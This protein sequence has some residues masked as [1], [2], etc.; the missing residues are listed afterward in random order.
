MSP[1][2]ASEKNTPKDLP[3]IS[4][5]KKVVKNQGNLINPLTSLRNYFYPLKMKGLKATLSF[6]DGE[7][8]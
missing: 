4:S 8:T 3:S 1:L 5:L 6:P 2:F 7:L